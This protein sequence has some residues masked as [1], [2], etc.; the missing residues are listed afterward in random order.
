VQDGKG[1]WEIISPRK[2][3]DALCEL[4]D[5]IGIIYS[6]ASIGAL[7][8]EEGQLAL[9]KRQELVLEKALALGYY[10]LPRRIT[11]TELAEKLNIA[12][13]TLSGILRR[14]SKKLVVA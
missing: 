4:F 5:D 10:E 9:T 11:L 7:K 13:S 12:K 8:K 3:I 2:K 1:T 14:I 6:I